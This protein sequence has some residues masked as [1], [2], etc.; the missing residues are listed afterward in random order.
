MALRSVKRLCKR[1]EDLAGQLSIRQEG[2]N[3]IAMVN[4]VMLEEDVM[5]LGRKTVATTHVLDTNRMKKCLKSL[6]DTETVL[7]VMP[8]ETWSDMRVN[9]R[10][11]FVIKYDKEREQGSPTPFESP[12]E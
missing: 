11:L 5:H 10:Y 8:I 4:S 6:L 1:Y 3:V 12:F 7:S 9:E 2:L